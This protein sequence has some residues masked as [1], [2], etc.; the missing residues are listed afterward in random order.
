MLQS[1][2]G[3]WQW[4]GGVIPWRIMLQAAILVAISLWSYYPSLHGLY[5]WDDDFLIQN[6]DVVHA[7]EGIAFIWSDP[8]HAL[9]D[10]FPL[11]V[12]V[13]WLIW[14]VFFD[15]TINDPSFAYMTFYFH[16]ASLTLHIVN[17]MLIWYLFRRLGI[18]LAWFGA[19]LFAV[20]PVLVESVAWMA[21]LKN[22]VAMPPFLLCVLAWLG[23]DRKRKPN[24]RWYSFA[25]SEYYWISFILYCVALLCKTSVVSLPVV[26]LLY[27]WWKHGKIGFWNNVQSMEDF[28]GRVKLAAA[29]WW[30]RLIPTIPFFVVAIADAWFLIL[31]LRHGVGE[32]FIPG[33]LG[34]VLGRTVCAGLCL[35]FYFSKSI[36][37]LNLMPIYTQWP[38]NPPGHWWYYLMWP[39]IALGFWLLWRKR[40]EPW[41]RTAIFG[42]AYYFV[43][44]GPFVGWRAISFMRFQWVMDHFQ[45]VP[46]LGIVGLAAAAASDIYYRLLRDEPAWRIAAVAVAAG[47]V[48]VFAFGSHR[49]SKVFVN[50]L[51]YWTYCESRNWVSWPSHNNR[52]NELLSKAQADFQIGDREQAAKYMAEAKQELLIALQ[53]NPVYTEAYNNIGYILSAEGHFREAEAAFRKA[54]FYTPDFESAQMNLAHVLTMENAQLHFNNGVILAKQGKYQAA[55]AELHASLQYAP[56]NPMTQQALMQ[57]MQMEASAP[58]PAPK[59]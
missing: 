55:E 18:R 5:L 16:S 47:L 39:L 36:L 26:I 29:E 38:V 57:V 1:A 23:Y 32:Q 11:T 9:I 34:G 13:E 31:Y 41:V 52:G 51:S 40:S 46:I 20:H 8:Q 19:L 22:T 42:F 30:P 27:D 15:P 48:T 59:K 43:M 21:E 14:Q 10:F 53:L 37:P 25:L 45:Y 17:L 56:N 4:L 2:A 58:P 54:L 24:G 44:I 3:G 12:S 7:P 50:R 49:Y 33:L 6:N 35:V 28:V